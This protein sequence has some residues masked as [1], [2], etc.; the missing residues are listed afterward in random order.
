MFASKQKR[1]PYASCPLPLFPLLLSQKRE[2]VVE[3]SLVKE[4]TVA[5]RGS[6]RVRMDEPKQTLYKFL[7]PHHCGFPFWVTDHDE[8][9]LLHVR[10]CARNA[11]EMSL[12][13]DAA[14]CDRTLNLIPPNPKTQSAFGVSLDRRRKV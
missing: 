4:E 13:I 11:S 1:L 7:I 9:E 10:S 5:V 2:V 8:N 14:R 6:L 12:S 3:F